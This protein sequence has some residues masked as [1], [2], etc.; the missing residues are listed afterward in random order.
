VYQPIRSEAARFTTYRAKT[1]DCDRLR[2]LWLS[3]GRRPAEVG[4]LSI[5]GEDHSDCEFA[6]YDDLVRAFRALIN[7]GELVPRRGLRP[8]VQRDSRHGSRRLDLT[9][10]RNSPRPVIQ[11]VPPAATFFAQSRQPWCSRAS[12]DGTCEAQAEAESRRRQAS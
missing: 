6:R 7:D 10:S 2:A 3:D 11:F 1:G 9:D 4:I 5:S 8:E 12:P